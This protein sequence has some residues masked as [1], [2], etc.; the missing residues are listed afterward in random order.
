VPGR[1][2]ISGPGRPFQHASTV[3]CSVPTF[4]INNGAI[5]DG[6]V[7][8]GSGAFKGA[9]GDLAANGLNKAGIRT[10]VNISYRK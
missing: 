10:A 5:S 1:V 2:G 3:T 6:T 8:G 7:K 4:N 9:T